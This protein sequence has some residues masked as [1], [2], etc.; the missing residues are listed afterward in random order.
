[1]KSG[2]I[3]G[4]ALLTIGCGSGPSGQK[5]ET[6]T[7]AKPNAPQ[8]PERAVASGKVEM[9]Q[10]DE[11]REPQW[12]V[13]AQS[14]ELNFDSEKKASGN[15]QGV[16]GDLYDKGKVVSTFKS[17]AGD[18]DQKQSVLNLR[19][20]VV[21]QSKEQDAVLTA[22]SVKWL[23]KLRLVKAEGAVQVI[24]KGYKMGPFPALLATPDLKKVGT[25]DRFPAVTP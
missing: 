10:R 4:C 5:A 17:N 15:L 16:S 19:G 21:V 25:P 2:L 1:M 9:V 8:E 3:V 7:S 23:A 6:S 18:V 11:Q 13:K 20:Q 24:G 14:A 12:A 22:D